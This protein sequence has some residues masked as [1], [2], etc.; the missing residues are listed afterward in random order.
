MCHTEE[1]AAH[2]KKCAT[3]KKLRPIWKN[4]LNLR[5]YGT[6]GKMRP[7]EEK[8]AQLEKCPK[9]KKMRQTWKNAHT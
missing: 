4:A 9:L 5:K 1:N 3:L 6:F 8:T 7:A 2:S